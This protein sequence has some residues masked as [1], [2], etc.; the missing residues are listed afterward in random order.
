M[1]A[2]SKRTAMNESWNTLSK[3]P[4]IAYTKSHQQEME[5]D[6][7]FDRSWSNRRHITSNKRHKN[8]SRCEEA[9]AI[10]RE[11]ASTQEHTKR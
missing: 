11:A 2:N 10:F 6:T 9:W 4:R 5:F 1:T 7:D 8:S 3:R